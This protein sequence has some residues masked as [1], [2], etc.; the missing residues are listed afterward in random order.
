[1]RMT[2]LL[3]FVVLVACRTAVKRVEVA[4]AD[5]PAGRRCLAAAEESFRRCR[6]VG[7]KSQCTKLRNELVL[8]CPAP[9]PGETR[10]EEEPLPQLPGWH[11]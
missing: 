6:E 8:E 4:I 3:V 7:R 5:T 10:I 9:G 11:P 1:M 2:A